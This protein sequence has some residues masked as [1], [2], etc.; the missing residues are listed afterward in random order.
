MIHAV[1]METGKSAGA[2]ETKQPQSQ[3]AAGVG[4]EMMMMMMMSS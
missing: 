4:D 1:V 2:E 3:E